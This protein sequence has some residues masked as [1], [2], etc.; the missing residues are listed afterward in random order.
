MNGLTQSRDCHKQ[1]LKAAE[2]GVT[3]TDPTNGHVRNTTALHTLVNKL[4]LKLMI[5]PFAT[6]HT[7]IRR[8]FMTRHTRTTSFLN[9]TVQTRSYSLFSYVTLIATKS[10]KL[11]S[12]G[13]PIRHENSPKD[14]KHR[15]VSCS[16]TEQVCCSP[17]ATRN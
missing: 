10:S 5:T 3:L 7:F 16:V 8:I 15:E 12:W 14:K 4:K 6:P 1:R 13:Q 11:K 17:L 9:E 2:C